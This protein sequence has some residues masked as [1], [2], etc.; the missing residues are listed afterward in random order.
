M[1]DFTKKFNFGYLQTLKNNVHTHKNNETNLKNKKGSHG[2]L[3][4]YKIIALSWFSDNEGL[5]NIIVFPEC[6][7]SNF[8]KDKLKVDII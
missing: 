6:I 3:F 1:I 7:S 8:D 2:T 4:Y 5:C